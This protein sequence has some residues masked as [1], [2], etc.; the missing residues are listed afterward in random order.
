MADGPIL[1]D[2]N[3]WE[4]LHKFAL[5][6]HV[7][8]RVASS[9]L[10]QFLMFFYCSYRRYPKPPYSYAGL[11]T[12][13]IWASPVGELSVS[14]I[15]ASLR[16][17]FAF[18]RCDEYKG[19]QSSVRHTLTNTDCF[20]IKAVGCH[21]RWTVDA[22]RVPAEA[23]RRQTTPESRRVQY[24]QHLLTHLAGSDWAG[25]GDAVCPNVTTNHGSQGDVASG[26]DVP[27]PPLPVWRPFLPS[28]TS[29]PVDVKPLYPVCATP[30]PPSVDACGYSHTLPMT[31]GFEPRLPCL[32]VATELETRHGYP[33]RCPS[34][35]I[36]PQFRVS[37]VISRPFDIESLIS[38]DVFTPAAVPYF[39]PPC[40]QASVTPDADIRYLSSS[41]CPNC[42]PRIPQTLPI[43]CR[44]SLSF[45]ADL[46]LASEDYF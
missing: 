13:A 39:L 31:R 7:Q 12:A 2:R 45:L 8:V 41:G 25:Q 38:P 24:A 3:Y 34:R 5:T 36:P 30:A 40:Y 32:P 44:N 21:R 6:M 29:S 22:A 26:P 18:F 4:L 9:L 1:G 37:P 10:L 42:A 15:Y 28:T 33:D 23:F 14:D 11:I 20:A 46:A 35:S 19:W 27:S 16:Q 43:V 17:M